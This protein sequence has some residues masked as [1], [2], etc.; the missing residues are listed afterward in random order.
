MA[1]PT[2]KTPQQL[3][4]F[5]PNFFCMSQTHPVDHTVE[6]R[7]FLYDGSDN[8]PT[9]PACGVAVNAVPAPG[10]VVTEE[11]ARMARR[12]AGDLSAIPK[13]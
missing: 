3:D 5:K 9:C 13:E 8:C 11:M 10:G 1:G 7:L 6:S 4:E 2:R 12:L